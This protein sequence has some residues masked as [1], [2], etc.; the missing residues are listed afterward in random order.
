M[1]LKGHQCCPMKTISLSFTFFAQILIYPILINWHSVLSPYMLISPLDFVHCTSFS[2]RLWSSCGRLH[3]SFWQNVDWI[4][5]IGWMHRGHVE[6]L[7]SGI[8]CRGFLF[9]GSCWDMLEF[10]IVE[11]FFSLL[12]FSS[13]KPSSSRW[14]SNKSDFCFWNLQKLRTDPRSCHRMT[15]PRRKDPA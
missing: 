5:F 9:S 7:R 14:A 12:S 1:N 13:L 3:F 10:C 2:P 6:F 15:K 8:S 11:V 4:H